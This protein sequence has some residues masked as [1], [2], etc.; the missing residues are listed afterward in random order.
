MVFQKRLDEGLWSASEMTGRGR[1]VRAAM[2]FYQGLL[3]NLEE[4]AGC[5]A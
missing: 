2:W 1:E 4:K 5:Q 3:M